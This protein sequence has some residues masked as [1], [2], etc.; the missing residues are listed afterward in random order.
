MITGLP[1][2]KT[3]PLVES[4]TGTSWPITSPACT[5]TAV[6][7]TNVSMSSSDPS[8]SVGTSAIACSASVNSIARSA[9]NRSAPRCGS[10][11]D[12]ACPRSPRHPSSVPPPLRA[13][14]DKRPPARGHRCDE[15]RM[16][17]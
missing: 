11:A 15:G 6:D 12:S 1:E 8:T 3:A 17:L 14:A 16:A 13:V 5:P 7:T 10:A 9:I 4:S 2:R